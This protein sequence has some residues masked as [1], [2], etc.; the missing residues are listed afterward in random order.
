MYSDHLL[1]IE[2]E[3]RFRKIINREFMEDFNYEYKEFAFE[4]VFYLTSYS[5]RCCPCSYEFEYLEFLS[6]T[7]DINEPMYQNL[8]QTL[9]NKKCPHVEG[10]DA[11]FFKITQCRGFH[12]VAAVEDDG[13]LQYLRDTKYDSEFRYS[14]LSCGPSGLF[15][16]TPSQMAV[17]KG[18]PKSL[19]VMLDLYPGISEDPTFK[20][21]YRS[22]EDRNIIR[23]EESNFLERCVR[24]NNIPLLKTFI[25]WI[26]K[27]GHM[28]MD[29]SGALNF[30]IVHVKTA[31]ILNILMRNMKRFGGMDS[32]TMYGPM[33]VIECAEMATILNEYDI[34]ENLLGVISYH[35]AIDDCQPELPDLCVRLSRPKCKEVIEKYGICCK[36]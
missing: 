22:E 33:H 29:L 7:G 5:Y 19:G 14:Y 9:R 24:K 26:K 16:I 11:K 23:F 34:L 12:I 15:G 10:V 21:W 6:D 27:K 3:R 32:R 2:S 28:I 31:D 25:T 18:K 1:P 35:Y 4:T 36:P 17:L 13:L 8:L 20:F 30:A